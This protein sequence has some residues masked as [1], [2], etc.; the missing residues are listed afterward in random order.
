MGF[1]GF[2]CPP[3]EGQAAGPGVENGTREEGLRL[4]VSYLC[5]KERVAGQNGVQPEVGRCEGSTSSQWHQR[6]ASFLCLPV[7]LLH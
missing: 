1:V 2:L 4:S 3:G 5:R 7:F 6:P